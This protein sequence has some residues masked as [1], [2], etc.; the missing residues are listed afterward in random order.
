M[1]DLNHTKILVK[2]LQDMWSSSAVEGRNC[3]VPQGSCLDPLLFQIYNND[4]P[5]PMEH[6][7]IKC[8]YIDDIAIGSFHIQLVQK[9]DFYSRSLQI[10]LK[11]TP[12]IHIIRE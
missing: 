3:E 10:L 4:L 2:I 12:L 6:V 9:S 8:T 1:T 5:I 7:I 11:F